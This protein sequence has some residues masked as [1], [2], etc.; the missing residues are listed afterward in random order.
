MQPQE[1]EVAMETPGVAA[2]AM[3]MAGAAGMSCAIA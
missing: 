3:A 2:E 1:A